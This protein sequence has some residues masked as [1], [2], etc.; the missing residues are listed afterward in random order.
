MS[1]RQNTDDLIV[2]LQKG[3][4]ALEQIAHKL[5]E[6]AERRF[7]KGGEVNPL[8]LAKRVRKLASELPELQNS[9]RDLLSSKQGL[10]DAA[11]RQLAANHARLKKLCEAAG[12]QPG[13]EDAFQS[14][15]ASMSEWNSKL[16]HHSAA[17]VFAERPQQRVGARRHDVQR[18]ST[19]SAQR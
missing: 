15:Q 9:C 5:E 4:A 7:C 16:H 14:F 3:E 6:E 11:Q 8:Q 12:M 17:A 1:V 19:A 10:V 2:A 13:D 18:L